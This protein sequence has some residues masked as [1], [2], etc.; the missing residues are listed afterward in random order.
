MTAKQKYL[1]DLNGYLHIKDVLAADELSNAQAAIDRWFDDDF[2][3]THPDRVKQVS[4]KLLAND[5]AWWCKLCQSR[6]HRRI[7]RSSAGLLLLFFFVPLVSSLSPPAP[8]PPPP[9]LCL[10]SSNEKNK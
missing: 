8:P 2:K 6:W 4:E 1:F 7:P 10:L 5:L 3:A 9:P